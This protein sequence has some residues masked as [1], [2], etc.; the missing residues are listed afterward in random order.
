MFQF[1]DEPS[2]FSKPTYAALLALLDNYERMTG[3]TEKFTAQQLAE[4]DTFLTETM[5]NTELGRELFAFFYTKGND[6]SAG[7]DVWLATAVQAER[8]KLLSQR[9]M[10]E[11][12]KYIYLYIVIIYCFISIFFKDNIFSLCIL[13]VSIASVSMKDFRKTLS[14][15]LSISLK[16]VTI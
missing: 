10:Y 15:N 13:F 11:T 2:L 6:H 16:I 8:N 1:L 3:Q 5:S 12:Y 4:Q 14:P 9:K 7:V